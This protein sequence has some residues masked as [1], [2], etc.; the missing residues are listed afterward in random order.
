MDGVELGLF[1]VKDNTLCSIEGAGFG[2]G[3]SEA[4]AAQGKRMG[5][6]AGMAVVGWREMDRLWDTRRQNCRGGSRGSICSE[7]SDIS[8][9][10]REE[11]FGKRLQVLDR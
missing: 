11:A 6:W 10:G 9:Q 1:I 7:E 2:W 3:V 8:G 5:A 4:V